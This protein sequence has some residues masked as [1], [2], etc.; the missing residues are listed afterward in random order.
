MVKNILGKY[1]V[2]SNNKGYTV[3]KR[4]KNKDGDWTKSTVGYC[5]T[6]EEVVNLIRADVVHENITCEDY[7]LVEAMKM[8][9][10][11]TDRIKKALEGI[12]DV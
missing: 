10:K 6:F 8:I 9:R 4:K 2:M 7:E 5:G 3:V 12:E 11:E 1:D